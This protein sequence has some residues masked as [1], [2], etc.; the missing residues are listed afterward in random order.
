MYV[1]SMCHLCVFFVVSLFTVAYFSDSNTDFIVTIIAIF[2]LLFSII[3]KR[4]ISK[5]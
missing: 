5:I 2:V 3:L 4:F 1:L